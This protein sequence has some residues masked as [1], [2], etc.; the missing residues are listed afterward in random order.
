MS[1]HCKGWKKENKLQ[2]TDNENAKNKYRWHAEDQGSSWYSSL[3]WLNKHFIQIETT[4]VEE[5]ET[6]KKL[7]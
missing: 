3:L 2:W 1:I 7:P 4:P 5:S 6:E